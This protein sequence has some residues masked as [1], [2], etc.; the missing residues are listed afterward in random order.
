MS[1]KSRTNHRG[2]INGTTLYPIALALY[3]M[4]VGLYFF[5]LKI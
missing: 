1:Y 4:T 3:V 5:L 2:G